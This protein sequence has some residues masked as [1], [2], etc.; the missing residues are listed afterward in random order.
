V[1]SAVDRSG[2]SEVDGQ[3]AAIPS[4]A[5]RIFASIR[6]VTENRGPVIRTV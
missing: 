5:A 6:V 3:A 4:Q 2:L 1:W